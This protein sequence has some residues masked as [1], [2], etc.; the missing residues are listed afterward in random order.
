MLTSRAVGMNAAE[1][2][3]ADGGGE[4]IWQE[5][6]GQYYGAYENGNAFVRIWLEEERS[7]ET[8]LNAMDEAGLAGVACWQLGFE[9]PEIWDVIQAYLNK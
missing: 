8:R 6:I 3:L 2:N 4:K 9:K 7:M 5:D 1:K